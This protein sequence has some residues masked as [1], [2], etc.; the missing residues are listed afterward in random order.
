MRD[1]DLE[2]RYS[3]Q[4]NSDTKSSQQPANIKHTDSFSCSLQDTS[5]NEKGRTKNKSCSPAKRVTVSG[6]EGTKE[7]TFEYQYNQKDGSEM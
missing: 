5:Y 1:L 2:L 7:G 4:Q 6:R 3:F